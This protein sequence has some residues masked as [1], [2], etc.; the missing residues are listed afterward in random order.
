MT[1]LS[2]LC[3]VPLLAP[4]ARAAESVTVHQPVIRVEHTDNGKAGWILE[5]ERAP[6][7]QVLAEVGTKSGMTIHFSILPQDTVT[8]TCAGD[9]VEQ[10]VH[11]L[12]G[13]DVNL[14]MRTAEPKPMTNGAKA[15]AAEELWILGSSY[16]KDRAGRRAAADCGVADGAVDAKAM[17]KT[18][19]RSKLL[20]TAASSRDEKARAGALSRLISEAPRGD[21]EVRAGLERALTDQSGDVRA[22]AVYGLALRVGPEAAPLLED[23]L[24][25]ADPSVRLMA[26]GS[27]WNDDTG[28]ALLR[29][30]VTDPDETVRALAVLKLEERGEAKE[31]QQ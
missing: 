29:S 17:A 28:A 14:V 4:I 15:Q 9:T 16:A 8:A 20:E 18:E 27:A 26:V 6:L 13:A 12:L 2:V 1:R 5:A 7:A 25:D 22:Q 19:N 24:R 21:P 3:M 10:I 31:E 23:A 11:C 30:A